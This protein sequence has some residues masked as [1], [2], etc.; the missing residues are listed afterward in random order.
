[1]RCL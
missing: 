1:L